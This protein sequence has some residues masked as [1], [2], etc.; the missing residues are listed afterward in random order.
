[1]VGVLDI[2]SSYPHKAAHEKMP[3]GEP[4]LTTVDEHPD[5][6]KFW[7]ADALVRFTLKPNRVP[8]IPTKAITEQKP[9][10]TEKWLANSGGVVRMSFCSVDYITM[11]S[12]YHIEFVQWIKTIHF[13]QRVHKELTAFVEKNNHIK[14]ENRRKAKTL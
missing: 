1:G 10:T 13:K 3:Y 14:E 11:Q 2:N 9:I 4:I 8:C 6:S 5:M 12:S 7:I